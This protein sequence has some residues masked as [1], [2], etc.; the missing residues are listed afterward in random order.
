MWNFFVSS[1]SRTIFEWS[2]LMP[3]GA[4]YFVKTELSKRKHLNKTQKLVQ[5][6]EP[7][8]INEPVQIDELVQINDPVQINAFVQINEP[9]YVIQG[10]TTNKS[11]LPLFVSWKRKWFF[12]FF[13][14]D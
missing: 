2:I 6:D 13:V 11:A 14:T 9:I 1:S 4:R 8:H 12:G 3:S 7:I 5:I 10:V